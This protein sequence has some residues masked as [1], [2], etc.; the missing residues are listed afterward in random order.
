LLPVLNAFPHEVWDIY[1][2]ALDANI[3]YGADR[4]VTAQRMAWAA[5]R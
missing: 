1:R 4:E 2:G 5:V 3:R